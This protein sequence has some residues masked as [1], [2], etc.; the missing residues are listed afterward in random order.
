MDIR[1]LRTVPWL[2]A[3]FCSLASLPGS[4]RAEEAAKLPIKKIVLFT[5]G[6]GY[7]EHGG[8]V[9][10]NATVDMKFNA[11][12]IN[13]LLKSMVLEDLDGGHVTAVTYGS[14]DPVART[15]ETFSVDVASEPSVAGLL[16]QLR[17]EKVKIEAAP[18]LTGMILG[19]ERRSELVK[20]EQLQDVDWLNLLT[21]VGLK[22]VRLSDIAGIE[23]VDEKLDAELRQALA[24]L[25]SG[26]RSEA[27][28]LSL[29]FDGEGERRV[30]VGYI[31]ETPIWKTTYRLVVGE[32][33]SLLQGWAIVE[34]VGE[35]QWEGVRLS[36]ISG[37]PISF[38]MDLDEPIYVRRPHA[39]LELL[40][41]VASRLH[42]ADL[43]A[44][45]AEFLARGKR[46]RLGGSGGGGFGGGFG[47]VG[48]G[49][50]GGGFG[51]GGFGGGGAFFGGSNTPPEQEKPLDPGQGVDA[52]ATGADVGELFQYEIE[53]PVTLAS[54]KSALLPIVD[55]QVQVEKLSV[56]N[57]STH[58]RHPLAALR[59]NNSTKLHLMQ[60]PITV[61]DGGAYAGDAR[62][63]SIPPG[64][65]R[66]VTYA[67]DLEVEVDRV[68]R[69]LE[70]T[71]TQFTVNQGVIHIQHRE[72]QETVYTIKNSR[73]AA[74]GVLVEHPFRPDR[75][76]W[77]LIAPE[78]P[79]EKTREEYRFLVD[80]QP[81]ETAVL[82]V[83]EERLVGT[84]VVITDV[85]SSVLVKYASDDTID[86]KI[87]QALADI[88]RRR[89]ALEDLI[90]QRRQLEAKTQLIH[91]EQNRIR[92]NIQ[93]VGTDAKIYVR[94][95]TKFDTQEDELE[96]IQ[97][98]TSQLDV[99]L[100]KQQLELEGTVNA[101]VLP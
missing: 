34:N 90:A 69:P 46:G 22:S 24:L 14:K 64:S 9:D 95:L 97:K 84:Q 77:K 57:A 75:D 21:E 12:D 71:R 4:L 1:I 6:V 89:S 7:F 26:R 5:S 8:R 30:R 58:Q 86:E 17:G 2:L 53:S 92:S 13:D 27:K 11:A 43:A 10:G 38:V 18:P 82:T 83:R 78:Q 80:A 50:G 31:R 76:E 35:T 56:Y 91:Q 23:L 41:S 28:P 36:L 39:G 68:A 99:D 54:H 16:R 51:G 81:G 15:L 3:V 63:R 47:G 74:R 60:G 62:V 66:L 20:H 44:R 55:A 100:R 98:Q 87:Q 37:Q 40:G 101:L 42:E 32:E 65:K 29:R 52:V 73:D 72:Q 33:K 61:F 67:L 45:E 48:G 88:V 79:T 19:I 96:Q 59:L 49:F 85:D 93:S 25:A 94:Y 70:T